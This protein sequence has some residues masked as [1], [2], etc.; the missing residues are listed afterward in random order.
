MRL[1]IKVGEEKLEQV[2]QFNYLRS[3]LKENGH[4]SKVIRKQIALAKEV[5]INRK[6][7]LR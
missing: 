1:K 5:F 4:N 3:T 2:E 6:E 7:F